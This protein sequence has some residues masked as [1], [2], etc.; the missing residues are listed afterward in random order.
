MLSTQL[1]KQLIL[2]G[3]GTIIIVILVFAQDTLSGLD[4][5]IGWA[6]LD[7]AFTLLLIGSKSDEK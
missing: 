1:V 3:T 5:L 6:I 2:L 7:M 4:N